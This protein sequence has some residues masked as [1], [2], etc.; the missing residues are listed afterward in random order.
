MQI[1][2]GK[3]DT[4]HVRSE[5]DRAIHAGMVGTGAYILNVGSRLAASIETAN[6][7]V[8]A[9]G[10]LLVQGTHARIRY[11]ETDTCIIENGTT[12]YNRID[13]IVARY[14]QVAGLE[15]VTLEVIK[16]EATAGEPS[17]PSY[18]EGN[19]LEGATLAEVPVYA[20]RISGVNVVSVTSK[21]PI[22]YTSMDNVYTK[23]EVDDK[24]SYLNQLLQNAVNTLNQRISNEVN[25]LS[26][27][28]S[29]V[30]ATLDQKITAQGTA[31]GTEFDT[32]YA[33]INSVYEDLAGQD[34][35]LIT[36]IDT[37]VAGLNTSI[38]NT[39]TSLNSA[40]N[41]LQAQ[42]NKYHGSTS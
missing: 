39:N 41:N 9:D 13:L 2:T 35:A 17:E 18:T 28:I 22:L 23:Q 14:T 24:D 33:R 32:V 34:A 1:I 31:M 20:V 16:G 40:V 38:S 4:A 42:I 10:E 19:I 12:G 21:I 30:G 3:T 29:N 37:A 25:A 5:D 15:S 7:I 11:G 6:N 36:K 26:Q 8:I 27:T